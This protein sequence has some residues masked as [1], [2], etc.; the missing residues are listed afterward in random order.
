M[1][2]GPG[3]WLGGVAL[4]LVDLRP[5]CRASGRVVTV[6]FPAAVPPLLR[7]AALLQQVMSLTP[8]QV[9]L[10]PPAQKAQVQALQQSLRGQ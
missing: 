7:P 8:E 6:P 5:G 1:G 9:E 10:L 3:G 2:Q 4:E